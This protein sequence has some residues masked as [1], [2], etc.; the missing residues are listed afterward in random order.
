LAYKQN[1]NEEKE[2]ITHLPQEIALGP[3]NLIYATIFSPIDMRRQ[4]IQLAV[5]STNPFSW[6]F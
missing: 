1:T 4:Q 2:F 3:Q 6:I 5:I